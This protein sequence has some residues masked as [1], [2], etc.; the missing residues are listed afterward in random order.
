M[1]NVFNLIAVT[2]TKSETINIINNKLIIYIKHPHYILPVIIITPRNI[3]NE[4]DESIGMI[5]GFW[6]IL[7]LAINDSIV[8]TVKA[9]RIWIAKN[10]NTFSKL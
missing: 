5:M 4:T 9:K 10:I 7:N 2:Q 3:N 8:P 1:I 6:F